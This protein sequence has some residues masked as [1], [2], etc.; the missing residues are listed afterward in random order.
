[1][2]PIPPSPSSHPTEGFSVVSLDCGI[3]VIGGFR[4]RKYSSYSDSR[5][6]SVLHLDCQ[7]HTWRQV[8]SMKVAR[9]K[10]AAGVVDGKIYVFGGCKYNET[11]GEVFDPKT[12]TW[13]PLPPVR[14]SLKPDLLFRNS[15]VVGEKIYAVPFSN[16]PNLLYYSPNKGI[17]GRGMKDINVSMI[18]TTSYCFSKAENVLYSCDDLGNVFWREPE[19][20]EWKKVKEGLGAQHNYFDK[21]MASIIWD[22]APCDELFKGYSKVLRN[23]GTNILIFWFKYN[24]KNTKVDIWCA[25][26]SFERRHDIGEIVGKTEWLQ[27]VAEVKG[28]HVKV[29]HS[30]YVNV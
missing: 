17:W 6:S 3:Y 18:G 8:P 14:D 11:Y 5:S 22:T 28:H 7:T 10:A 1:M 26:I 27:P 16:P 30:A 12:Q 9:C 25:E 23:F 19:D 2:T 20:S 15:M 29:L 13:T 21:P 4:K 24:R